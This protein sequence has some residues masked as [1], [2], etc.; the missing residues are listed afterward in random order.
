MDINKILQTAVNYKAS[1]IYLSQGIKPF[2]RINGKLHAIEAH[3]E[4]NEEI[5][6]NYLSQI[7]NEEQ[8]LN[9]TKHKDYDM[10]LE[11]KDVGRFRVNTFFQNKGIGIVLRFI[12]DEIKSID[13]LNLPHQL[14]KIADLKQG[15]VLVTGPTGQGKST[16]MS[17][18]INEINQ[19]HSYNIIT[20]EDPIEFV[21]KNKKSIIQQR[22][23][24]NHTKDYN[25]ALKSALRE[26]C[27]VILVGEMRDEK[28]IQLALTAAE[29]GHLVISTLHTSGAAKT[30][31]RII[32]SFSSEKQ[33]QI[34]SQLSESL[35]T[36]IWQQLVPSSDGK[37][38]VAALEI[39]NNNDAIGN[40]IRQNKTFQINSVIETSSSSGMITMKKYIENLL[41][42]GF[43][44]KEEALK[45]IKGLGI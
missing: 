18:I 24:E 8:Y 6:K 3:E 17:A 41:Q 33:N 13:E 16:T 20:I 25:T 7:L 29:T 23:V 22:E 14:K 42:T 37:S 11:V 15:I 12:P 40:L 35:R 21:Y 4:I 45:Y 43:I 28:T 36:V 9:F 34:R 1:D 32:D 19:N 38:R 44:S 26:S 27:D 31:D 10:A 2:L 5:I 39:M 30:V